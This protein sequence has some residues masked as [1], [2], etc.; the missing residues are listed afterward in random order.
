MVD[1][2]VRSVGGSGAGV[3]LEKQKLSQFPHLTTHYQ[4]P[5][6]IHEF[7]KSRLQH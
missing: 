1:A 4:A 5:E 2:R 7:W 3:D 6:A